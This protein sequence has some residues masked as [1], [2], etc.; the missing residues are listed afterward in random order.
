MATEFADMCCGECGIEFHVPQHFYDERRKTGKGWHCP[1]GHSR[2]FRESDADKFRRERDQA[3][4]EIA[5]IEQEREE[6]RARAE[7]AERATARLKKRASAG[8][9]PCCNRTFANMAEHMKGQHPEF[10]ADGGAT[11]VPIKRKAVNQ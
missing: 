10:V 9:C 11:V 8:T 2:V 4:Q 1:N 3:K 6:Q 7:K 5:R